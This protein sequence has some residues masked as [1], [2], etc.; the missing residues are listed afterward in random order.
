MSLYDAGLSFWFTD[1]LNACRVINIHQPRQQSTPPFPSNKD[2][3]NSKAKAG[4]VLNIE[5]EA[6]TAN[7]VID[8]MQVHTSG[9]LIQN[10]NL[11]FRSLYL[12]LTNTQVMIVIVSARFFSF[13]NF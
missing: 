5:V 11:V 2:H 7:A 10:L 13:Q 4:W 9:T 1:F 12:V 6:A 3:K 8:E